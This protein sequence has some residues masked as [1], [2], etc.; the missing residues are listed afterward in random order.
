MFISATISNTQAS[1]VLLILA[2]AVRV[3]ACR[4]MFIDAVYP[5]IDSIDHT[6]KSCSHINVPSGKHTKNYRKSPLFMGQ[7]T[8]NCDFP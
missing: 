6:H 8:I 5:A 7:L 1:C 3:H 2:D 4:R